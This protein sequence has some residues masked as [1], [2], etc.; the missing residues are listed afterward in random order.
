MAGPRDAFYTTLALVAPV[1]LWQYYR[2]KSDQKAVHPPSPMSLPLIGSLLSLP[3]GP[4]YITY[5]ELG[6]QLKSDIVYLNLFGHK[7]IVL[8]SS[9]AASDLLD[10]RSALYS[11]RFCPL[12][13]QD[14]E[15]LDWSTAPT[16]LG[17]NDVW[18]HHRRMMN[19]WLNVREASGFHK[20]QESK[21]RTLL[22]RLL[23]ISTET[24]IFDQ[25][26]DELFFTM[27]SSIFQA[28]YGYTAQEKDDPFLQ[29]GHELIDHGTDA[30]MVTNFFV[31]II[32]ALNLVPEWFPGAG[33]KRTI[34]KWR[35]QK[36]YAQSAPYQWTQNQVSQGTNEPSILGT[37]L[38]D[39]DLVS[40]LSPEDKEDRLKQLAFILYSAATDTTATLL[41]SFV[42][43]MILNPDVQ[44]QAQQ[45]ID[46]VLGPGVLPHVSDRERLPYVNRLI[47]ELLRWRPAAPIAIPHRCF[48]D[49]VYRGYNIR[50]GT[51]VIG[52]M[53]AMSRDE[54]DYPDPETFNPDRF[55]NPKVP[56][57]PAFGW[58]RRICPGMHFGEAS[59]FITITSLL[60]TLTFSK[61]RD[62]NGKY[63]EL[64][65][66]DAPNSLVMALKPFEFE[67]AP[68]S[69][70]HRRV[71]DEAI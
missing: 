24:H 50:K 67:F 39:H 18:R 37:L 23:R 21:A 28:S 54:K 69:E 27:G 66:E 26:K 14:K 57:L 58:G 16:I 4:E 62:S 60:A 29:A 63:I 30:V 53:W 64:I 33:W 38:Q 25:V 42:A 9:E 52:N 45:E 11:D 10:K 35:K 46:L 51:I 17:Y 2:A 13:F 15:L 65:I 7:I 59:L 31:N 71:I 49:D 8:N 20:L 68:R 6:K 40:G 41:V 32:P 61:K 5:T 12:I 36:E 70:M 19:K 55:L 44:L 56:P 48:Q 47:L 43:A 22:Q 1:L 3:S 34:R